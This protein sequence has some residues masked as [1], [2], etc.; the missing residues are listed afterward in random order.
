VGLRRTNIPIYVYHCDQCNKDVEVYQTYDEVALTVC[1]TCG[2]AIHRVIQ[3]VPVHYK[4]AGFATTEA[5]GLT[6]H[7][8][9][10]KITVGNR[11]TRKGEH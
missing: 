9:H 7:K 2:G 3:L 11:D 4:A 1:E 10:P 5:R 8:R 6:G